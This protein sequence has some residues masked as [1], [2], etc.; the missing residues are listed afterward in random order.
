[1]RRLIV[2]FT[3][4]STLKQILA[5]PKAKAVLEK[6]APGFSNHPLLGMAMG[7][8]L[9]QISG[10]PQAGIAADKFKA[11]VDDLAKL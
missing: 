8:S 5:D 2:A 11:I 3:A 9:K 4:D 1:M 6:H 10:F 7:M